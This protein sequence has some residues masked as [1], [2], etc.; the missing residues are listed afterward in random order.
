LQTRVAALYADD[1]HAARE[2]E[3]ARESRHHV[4]IALAVEFYLPR[5]VLHELRLVA[6]FD[7][8]QFIRA[9]IREHPA[10]EAE[11]DEADDQQ[12]PEHDVEQAHPPE[13]FKHE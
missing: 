13:R 9:A 5:L 3:G 8:A 10:R 4:A 11:R 12:S 7:G 6:A 2:F 1:A